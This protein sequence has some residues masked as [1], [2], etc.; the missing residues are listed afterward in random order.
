MTSEK[1]LMPGTSATATRAG[2]RPSWMSSAAVAGRAPAGAEGDVGAGLPVDVRDP[3]AVVDQPQAGPARLLLV[4]R[5]DRREVL[6][7]EEPLEVAR[8]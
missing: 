2:P 3:V 6:G 1:A 8:A 7:E 5:A 4:G